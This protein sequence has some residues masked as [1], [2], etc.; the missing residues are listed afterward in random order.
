MKI[1]KKGLL[2]VATLPVL[3]AG[4][5]IGAANANTFNFARANATNVQ[6]QNIFTHNVEGAHLP[7]NAVY[8]IPES[9]VSWWT[10]GAETRFYFQND[11]NSVYAWSDVV[12]FAYNRG[13]NSNKPVYE[14]LVPDFPAE[15]GLTAWTKFQAIRGVTG[16]TPTTIG[17]KYDKD[18][19]PNGYIYN[20]SGACDIY[21][22]SAYHNTIGYY[23]DGSE[24]NYC[25]T[26]TAVERLE[27]LSWNQEWSKPGAVGTFCKADGSTDATNL[28]TQW[29]AT[30]DIFE[31]LGEDVQYYF[32]HVTA[33]AKEEITE[34]DVADFA[35]R[36]DWVFHRYATAKSLTNWADRTIVL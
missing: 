5:V 30:K 31:D 36:Y 3:A 24:H 9:T 4:I 18:T 1:S 6:S 7:G 14:V 13:N 20:Y 16:K 34:A 10:S 26:I 15:S 28:K 33:E 23:N 27:V 35:A 2:A 21:F 8:F 29:D 17:D 19:N 22:S 32:S 25:D 11:D 12:T